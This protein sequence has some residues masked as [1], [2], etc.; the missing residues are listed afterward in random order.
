M[1]PRTAVEIQHEHE[2][3]FVANPNVVTFYNQGQA[4]VRN[5]I[6]GEA[7]RC[8][9][10]GV[11]AEI[12]RDVIRA[13]DPTVDDRPERPFRFTRGFVQARTYLAQ[14]RLFNSVAV[15]APKRPLELEESVVWLLDQVVEGIY[16]NR[17]TLETTR[18][19]LDVVHDAEKI[20][21]EHWN[22]ELTLDAIAAQVGISV[23]HLCRIFRDTTG[24]SQ[25]QY[26]IRLRARRSLE[27]VE[28][29]RVGLTDIAL[30]SGF[31]THSH[32]SASFRSEFGTTPSAI[33]T[34]RAS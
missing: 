21:S 7:D 1:F 12:A 11:S 2:R 22:E 6:S 18:C 17:Q 5:A 28:E 20:L 23:Y 29:S 34:R 16:G 14:R 8:D 32:F 30:E 3:A 4:Y 27:I 31:C 19:P 33:R 10:F 26:R 9:W 13:Y 25:H 24:I 15:G